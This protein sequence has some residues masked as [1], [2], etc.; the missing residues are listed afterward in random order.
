MS[1][2]RFS[3]R[4]VVDMAKLNLEAANEHLDQALKELNRAQNDFLTA[5]KD[6]GVTE[7]KLSEKGDRLRMKRVAV[8]EAQ[9]KVEERKKE[10][11]EA[12]NQA[13]ESFS[14]R[15]FNPIEDLKESLLRAVNEVR[16]D[17]VEVQKGVVEVRNDVVEVQKGVVEVRNDVNE[18][19][20]RLEKEVGDL[21]R[22][23]GFVS[24]I[25]SALTLGKDIIKKSVLDPSTFDA[26]PATPEVCGKILDQLPGFE[27][28][29]MQHE[30]EEANVRAALRQLFEIVTTVCQLEVT[31]KDTSVSDSLKDPP[32]K[33]DFSVLEHSMSLWSELIAVMEVK[34]S[35]NSSNNY[36]T[37]A[38]Q[39]IDRF[40]TL[41]YHQ[42]ARRLVYGVILG[43]DSIELFK[44][45][46][47]R[48]KLIRSDEMTLKFE[49]DNK[50][51]RQLIG[52]VNATKEDLGYIKYDPP[53]VGGFS[54][55]L[56][57]VRPSES[58][59]TSVVEGTLT[60]V[61]PEMEVKLKALPQG[62]IGEGYTP[63]VCKFGPVNKL[64]KE[65]L[66]LEKLAKLIHTAFGSDQ[67]HVPIILGHEVTE[68][69]MAILTAPLGY[70]I[71]VEL[72]KLAGCLKAM[73]DVLL[74]LKICADNG[75]LH[76]DISYSNCLVRVVG[77]VH[78]G[79]LIDFNGAT[80]A[81]SPLMETDL[82]MTPLFAAVEVHRAF[83]KKSADFKHI[84]ACDV[85]AWFYTILYISCNGKLMWTS[86]REHHHLTRTAD[87]DYD[88]DERYHYPSDHPYSDEDEEDT[89]A[90]IK[91]HSVSDLS[92]LYAE[93]REGDQDEAEAEDNDEDD[94][95]EED[96]EDETEESEP[97]NH[98][99]EVVIDLTKDERENSD[100]VEMNKPS[101]VLSQKRTRSTIE[102]EEGAPPKK[103]RRFQQSALEEPE[104]VSQFPRAYFPS[105]S[106]VNV[107]YRMPLEDHGGRKVGIFEQKCA[108]SVE[109]RVITFGFALKRTAQIAMAERKIVDIANV[110]VYGDDMSLHQFRSTVVAK[111]IHAVLAEKLNNAV[112]SS[113]SCT[114]WT[115]EIADEIKTKLKDM[116]LP[117]YKYVV[118]VV[119]GEMRG[120]GV[121][122]GCRC[123]WDAD[124]DNMAQDVFINDSLFCVA[125]DWNLEAACDGYFQEG[126]SASAETSK[127][128]VGKLSRL[129][130]KYK[131]PDDNIIGVEGTEALCNDLEVDPTDVVTL[132]L[133][134][135]LKCENM[136]EF[137]REGWIAGWT[138]LECDTIEK[139]KS[140]IPEMRAA[141]DDP[142]KFKEIYQF[143][144]NFAKQ[145]SQK[146]LALDSAVAF[147]QLLFTGRFKR[148]NSWIQ[149]V[150]EHH[151]KAISKD[152]W[153]LFLDFTRS[154]KDDFSEHDDDEAWPVLIDEFVIYARE[155]Q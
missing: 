148:I 76:R 30:E 122:M 25:T 129:F 66:I 53:T 44:Y 104:Q 34:V 88:E 84:L 70:Q 41:K 26:F 145:E 116:S 11:H 127:V 109:K 141:L 151:G 117:R 130:D 22:P 89:D 75:I 90:L 155:Q 96:N 80:D 65:I 4:D 52:L 10:L 21:A 23:R 46:L 102:N 144:F 107:H 137:K 5:E 14:G 13:L 71:D 94:D 1:T 79:L 146:S 120:E 67:P 64:N 62:V 138:K 37:A 114:A 83:Q 154:C 28:R 136:C 7:A 134:Y 55:N 31:V 108:S 110:P 118:N 98:Q 99:S 45:D 78:H 57:L 32:G 58:R 95:G 49:K 113:D 19:I 123:L 68:K 125:V 35:L 73:R 139:M 140:K 56:V 18:K 81:G 115:K 3:Y 101:S 42:P 2:Q 147:W 124:S 24:S 17:V 74:V 63:V 8:R 112:Y 59:E 87:M 111:L 43:C 126:G 51:F 100:K 131:D 9:D 133:A 50:G 152:T 82:T 106:L 103:P 12:F 143:T 38:G 153:N 85:E 97:K 142:V 27:T 15:S 40:S 119:I 29:I 86:C 92:G 61:S 121:R 150:T 33:I 149:F 6:T 105:S 128:D 69:A 20:D 60:K 16:N 39:V 47:D 54:P 72:H 77:N 36:F 132:V 48:Q 91:L 93:G 135:Y